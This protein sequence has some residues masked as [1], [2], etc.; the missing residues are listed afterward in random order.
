MNKDLQQLIRVKVYRRPGKFMEDPFSV[1]VHESPRFKNVGDPATRGID[2]EISLIAI[3]S[4]AEDI[5]NTGG[6]EILQAVVMRFLTNSLPFQPTY[7][8]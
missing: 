3:L 6:S 8:M 5:Q 4:K 2:I 1:T 7:I